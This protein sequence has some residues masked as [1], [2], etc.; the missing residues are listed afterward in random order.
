MSNPMVIGVDLG[1]TH[2]RTALIDF[3]GNI[4][5]RQKTATNISLG[6]EQTTQRLIAECRALME[7][8]TELGAK[9]VGIGLGVAGKVDHKRRWVIFS[10]HLPAMRNYPL[11]PRI[12][13][14]LNVPVVLENDAN[15]FGLGESWVGAGCGVSNWVG[16]TLGTGVGGC[17]ILN[18][19]LWTGDDL[20]FAAE[21]GHL[22]VHPDGPPCACGLRGCLE[23]HA[24]GTALLEFIS[25]TANEGTLTGGPLY[26][27]WDDG[28][29]NARAV[30]Q[31]SLAGE[32]V[33]QR[34]FARMGWALGLALANL[35]T[36]LGIR[37]AIIGGGVSAG[38]DQF[39]EP[40]EKSLAAH[41]S[42]LVVAD[43]V[44]ERSTL[45]DDA[46]LLG[47]ARLALQR[48]AVEAA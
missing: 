15:V 1:G 17:L 21:I 19:R 34:A 26:E 38:W 45:G 46:A 16:L 29:L 23:A 40:L 11:G 33:A 31:C 13:G 3:R 18:G 22:I 24:S 36:V 5:R 48:H 2:M 37:T 47:A 42:M 27:L 44:V 28:H 12:E 30:Y 7:G 35:F 25:D 41:S 39:I 8:A 10:P 6:V 43:A 4:I 9:V 20:G 14:S 32:P